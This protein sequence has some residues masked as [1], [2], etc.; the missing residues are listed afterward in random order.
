MAHS[1][2]QGISGILDPEAP[3]AN[4]LPF[5]MPT[6]ECL[7]DD[8]QMDAW[9]VQM[10]PIST[11]NI[12]DDRRPR[13]SPP[14]FAQW[15]SQ[16]PFYHEATE[17]DF[18]GSGGVRLGLLYI[19][20]MV[21]SVLAKDTQDR[22]KQDGTYL[23]DRN[24]ISYMSRAAGTLLR[25]IHMSIAKLEPGHRARQRQSDDSTVFVGPST[26][27][28]QDKIP[29]PQRRTESPREKPLHGENGSRD[30]S[31]EQATDDEVS[32]RWCV[33]GI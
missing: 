31:R 21:A 26:E 18:G 16:R 11:F 28:W 29:P 8:E 30:S 32:R 6:L 27:L 7:S 10:L 14:Y 25:H 3:G 5:D 1:F 19:F 2:E 4:M 20:R 24:V 15:V 12:L 33:S 9:I 22:I 17:V 13:A 23:T